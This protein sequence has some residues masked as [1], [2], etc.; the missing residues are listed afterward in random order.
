MPLLLTANF[1][2]P[3]GIHEEHGGNGCVE[4]G[5]NDEL[6]CK[7]FGFDEMHYS[8]FVML[9]LAGSECSQMSGKSRFIVICL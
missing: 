1:K 7:H 8:Y 9:S 2:W 4:I 3:T 5:V 6:I